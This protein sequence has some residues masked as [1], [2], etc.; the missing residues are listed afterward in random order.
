M[1][2]MMRIRPEHE[3]P[4]SDAVVCVQLKSATKASAY[5]L[6]GSFACLGAGLVT[7]LDAIS[8][9]TACIR[10]LLTLWCKT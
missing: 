9:S 8:S 3:T 7:P 6:L 4:T 1:P 10:G 2:K 5:A